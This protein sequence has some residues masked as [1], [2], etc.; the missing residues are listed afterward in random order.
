MAIKRKKSEEPSPLPKRTCACGCE[1]EFQPSRSDQF[2]LNSKHYDFA[3]NHGLRKQKYKEENLATKVIRKNDRILEKY[4]KIMKQP[5]CTL[6]FVIVKAEGFDEGRFTRIVGL[7]RG[8][9]ELKFHALYQY[10]YRIYKQG[11]IT[12]IEIIE[13]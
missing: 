13:L 1:I 7:K 8:D 3:Y 4:I 12:Y 6:N 2:H 9:V 5:R 10:G 11:D